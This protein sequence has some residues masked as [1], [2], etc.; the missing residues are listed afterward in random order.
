MVNSMCLTHGEVRAQ[1][2]HKDNPVSIRKI[3]QAKR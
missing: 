3:Y 2:I 1:K